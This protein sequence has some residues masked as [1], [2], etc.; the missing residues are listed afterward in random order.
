MELHSD[1]ATANTV[2]TVPVVVAAPPRAPVVRVAPPVHSRAAPNIRGGGRSASERL[3]S[4]GGNAFDSI[5]DRRSPPRRMDLSNSGSSS[6]GNSN[7]SSHSNSN[8][9]SHSNSKRKRRRDKRRGKRAPRQQWDQPPAPPAPG[10][11]SVP[12]TPVVAVPIPLPPPPPDNK[13]AWKLCEFCW[14]DGYGEARYYIDGLELHRHEVMN[15]PEQV[16][17]RGY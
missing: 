12:P 10:P 4:E 5:G 9:Q 13:Y 16:E 1:V 6:E 11:R 14:R 7:S 2:A 8:S 3:A 15:H 17:L